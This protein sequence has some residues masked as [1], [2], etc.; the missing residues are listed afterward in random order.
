M[1]PNLDWNRLPLLHSRQTAHRLHRARFV[2]TDPPSDLR[3]RQA[4]NV[5]YLQPRLH[6]SLLERGLTFTYGMPTPD[7]TG[8]VM[9]NGCTSR[10]TVFF[11]S[12]L[13]YLESSEIDGSDWRDRSA[14]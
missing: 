7:D 14:R 1:S 3:H 2:M 12:R 6:R 4:R 8:F 13:K 9:E 11:V 10:P 5:T